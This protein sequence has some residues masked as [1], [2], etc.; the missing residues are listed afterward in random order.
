[1]AKFFLNN[2]ISFIRDV[3]GKKYFAVREEKSAR[4]THEFAVRFFCVW[5]IN[6]LP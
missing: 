6:L 3:D 4:Q 5:E 2:Y 1:M